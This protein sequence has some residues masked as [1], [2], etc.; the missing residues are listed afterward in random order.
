MLRMIGLISVIMI[1]LNLCSRCA[2][3][4]NDKVPANTG[5]DERRHQDVDTVIQ[6]RQKGTYHA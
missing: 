5:G 4:A 2:S 1:T 6:V 3:H